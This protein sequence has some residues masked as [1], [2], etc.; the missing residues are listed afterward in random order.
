MNKALE[1]FAVR[2]RKYNCSQ[3]V[4]CGLG[5]DELFEELSSC[6]GGQAPDGLCG[7]LFAAE[8]VVPEKKEEIAAGFA[9]KLGS[10]HCKVLKRE[11]NVPCEE[12]VACA[13]SLAEKY[14]SE[15]K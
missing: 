6:G 15:K 4:A 2:P 13:F 7:A 10:V 14:L 8:L 3:S 12:C 9:E 11:L 1:L 5:R